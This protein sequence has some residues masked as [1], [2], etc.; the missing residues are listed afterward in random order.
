MSEGQFSPKS[1]ERLQSC[2]SRLQILFQDVIQYQDCSIL[3]GHRCEADQNAA[4]SSGKSELIWPNSKHNSQPSLAVDAGP[5]PINWGNIEAFKLFGAF[6]KLRAKALSIPIRWG[7]DFHSF[8][9]YDH[10]ELV[11]SEQSD[12]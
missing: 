4:C 7:G 12:A 9:D 3:V 2:D 10:F 11:E 6:V 1:L 5:S 8:K